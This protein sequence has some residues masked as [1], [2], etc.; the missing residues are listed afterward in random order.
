MRARRN[1]QGLQCPCQPRTSTRRAQVLQSE[2]HMGRKEAL[3]C[4]HPSPLVDLGKDG[5]GLLG[6]VTWLRPK[7]TCYQP[8]G[9]C[10]QMEGLSCGPSSPVSRPLILF[11]S[12]RHM[13]CAS[14]TATNNKPP[15]RQHPSIQPTASTGHRRL[16]REYTD[17]AIDAMFQPD[18][19]RPGFGSE[20]SAPPGRSE[21]PKGSQ[22]QGLSPP[23]TS[24]LPSDS[25]GHTGPIHLD[26]ANVSR[27]GGPAP[28]SAFTWRI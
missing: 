24:L 9:C 11:Q 5:S 17:P 19:K 28:H 3:L 14:H 27:V 8:R 10:P 18:M 22:G 2:L 4:P 21:H 20:C 6:V 15:K 1:A 16:K 25:L 7:D 13:A 23:I 12:H 26:S